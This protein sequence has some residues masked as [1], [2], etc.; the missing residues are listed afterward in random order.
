[1]GL[2]WVAV[3]LEDSRSCVAVDIRAACMPLFLVRCWS[4][5]SRLTGPPIGLD[6]RFA[7]ASAQFR[8]HSR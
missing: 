6:G 5:A 8:K 7:E 3:M 1:M 2:L 4:Q